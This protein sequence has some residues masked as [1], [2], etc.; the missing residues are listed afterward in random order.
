M[1]KKIVG[2]VEYGTELLELF[3]VKKFIF[4]FLSLEV[5]CKMF[6]LLNLHYL[7]SLSY[8]F[9]DMSDLAVVLSICSE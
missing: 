5:A 3:Q 6:L 7:P 1:I 9:V 2:V 4:L 8:K